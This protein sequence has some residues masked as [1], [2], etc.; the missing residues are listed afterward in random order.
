MKIRHSLPV[1]AAAFMFGGA[2][3]APVIAG[4][5]PVWDIEEFDKCAAALD[6]GMD[7]TANWNETVGEYCCKH[8]GGVWNDSQKKCVAPAGRAVTQNPLVPRGQLVPIGP[9][10]PATISTR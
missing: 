5:E 3:L 10:S 4:A 8:S 7:N 2:L 9:R 1:I 6:E